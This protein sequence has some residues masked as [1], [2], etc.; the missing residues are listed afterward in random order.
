MISFNCAQSV[1]VSAC[2]SVWYWGT[3][4]LPERLECVSRKDNV[5]LLLRWLCL[6]DK[7]LNVG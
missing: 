2:V 1:S 7:A 5:P 6:K 4:M 3:G